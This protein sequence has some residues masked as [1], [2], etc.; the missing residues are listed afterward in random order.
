MAHLARNYPEFTAD[1]VWKL[2]EPSEASTH[3]PRAM[4]AVMQAAARDHLIEATDRTTQSSLA[5]RHAR[6]VRVW[7]SLVLGAA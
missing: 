4:G 2:L 6:P 7:R 3:E 5:R 1:D